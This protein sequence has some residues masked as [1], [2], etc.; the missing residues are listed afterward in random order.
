VNRPSFDELC[1]C[2]L[3]HRAVDADTRDRARRAW[4]PLIICERCIR[5]ADD[6]YSGSRPMETAA[7]Q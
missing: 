2:D 3:C 5:E 1:R 6:Q 4:Q 7:A